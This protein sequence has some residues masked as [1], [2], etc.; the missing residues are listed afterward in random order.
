MEL[1]MITARF[2]GFRNSVG[3]VTTGKLEEVLSETER[4]RTESGLSITTVGGPVMKEAGISR[5][6]I[7][8]EV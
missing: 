8:K 4:E 1:S 7:R 6:E 5:V 2:W 3:R